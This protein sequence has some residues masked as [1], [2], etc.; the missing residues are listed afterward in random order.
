MRNILVLGAGKSSP[1]LIKYF[2]DSASHNNWKITVADNQLANAQNKIANHHTGIAVQV[3]INNDVQRRSLIEGADI[4]VSLLPPALHETV[5]DDCLDLN[6]NLATASY[7][8]PKMQ[9]RHNVAHKKG[10]IFL[11]EC[12]LDPG[13][14]HMSAMQIIDHIKAIGGEITSFKSY[15]GGLIAPQSNNNPWGYKFTWNPRNVILAGQGTAR[16]II[17]GQYKFLPYN[18]LFSQIEN[19]NVDGVIYDGYANRDSLSYRKHYGLENIPTIIRGTLRNHG[20]CT[21][22][23]IFVQL[24]LT[25]DTY[26]IENSNSLSYISLVDSFLPYSDLLSTQQKLKQFISSFTSDSTIFSKIESTGILSEELIPLSQGSPAAILQ[27]LLE[28]KWALLPTDLDQI[29]MSHIFNYKDKTGK[30]YQITSNLISIG[31][32]SI[33]TAMAKTV[34]LPLAIAVKNILNNQIKTKGV[35]IP[36]SKEVY[37][38]ILA[39]LQSFG[40]KLKENIV[41]L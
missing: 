31:H 12:G 40:I 8:S 3:D 38:P 1:F 35:V 18:R 19:I 26:I 27:N 25:D 4:V 34:G 9:E 2:L 23:N 28:K 30:P 20:F 7:V 29:V 17:N 11:N 21:A 14:D 37:E 10:L 39:E 5:A 33:Y 16:Y 22:W 32:D 6:K 15:T 41:E 24:G 36:V 13:I